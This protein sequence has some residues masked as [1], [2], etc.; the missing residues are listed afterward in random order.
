MV[1]DRNRIALMTILIYVSKC[2]SFAV[3]INDWFKRAVRVGDIF[4]PECLFFSYHWLRLVEMRQKKLKTQRGFQSERRGMSVGSYFCLRAHTY[5][6]R[7][8][9]AHASPACCR[10]EEWVLKLGEV[11]SELAARQIVL[12]CACVFS[13]ACGLLMFGVFFPLWFCC[14]LHVSNNMSHLLISCKGSL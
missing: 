6:H 7:H 4:H 12:L 1:V 2:F 10:S 8:K 3:S 14:F 13:A 9:H 11:R 5:M